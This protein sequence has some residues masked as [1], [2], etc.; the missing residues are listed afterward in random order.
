MGAPKWLRK[1]LTARG[2]RFD[3]LHHP[4][5]FTAQEV[6]HAEHFTGHRVAKVVIAMA[7]GQPVELILPASRYVRL[8]RVRQLL[9][10]EDVRLATEEEMARYFPDCEVGAVPAVRHWKGV[11][12]L[13]DE[14]LR[15]D[16]VI[17]FQAGTHEDAVQV[18]YNDWVK[19]V[20]PRVASFVYP[21]E[22]APV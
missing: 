14:S 9:D 12:I 2:I 13:M 4:P 7:D 19:L 22:P 6:A 11:P 18:Y 1:L 17:L 20:K 10:A 8:E 21:A 5:A 15:V 3:E 16:G